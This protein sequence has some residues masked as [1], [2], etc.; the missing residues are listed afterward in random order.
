[1]GV[2]ASKEN[3]ICVSEGTD[4]ATNLQSDDNELDA[5]LSTFKLKMGTKAIDNAVRKM[6]PSFYI[7]GATVGPKDIVVAKDTWYLVSGDNNP[8]FK[9]RKDTANFKYTASLRKLQTR[10]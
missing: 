9:R 1:M 3:K 7:R 2:K 5:A 10:S 6:L 8:E 4:C